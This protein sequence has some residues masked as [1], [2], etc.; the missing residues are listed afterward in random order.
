MIAMIVIAIILMVL[1]LLIV[2]FYSPAFRAWTEAPKYAMLERNEMF[3]RAVNGEL[4]D[5]PDKHRQ[6]SRRWAATRDIA[7]Q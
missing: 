4:N 3:E 6:V 2:W 7:N 1:A 5:H